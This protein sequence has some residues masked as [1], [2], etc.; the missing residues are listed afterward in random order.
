MIGD[1]GTA[2]DGLPPA[3][4]DNGSGER[5]LRVDAAVLRIVRLLGRQMAREEF[6]RLNAANE[7]RP[8]EN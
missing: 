3:A 8:P 7:D 6:E 5:W 2:D 4:N 1:E